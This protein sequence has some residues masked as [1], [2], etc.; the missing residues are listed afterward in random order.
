MLLFLGGRRE[1]GRR[2]RERGGRGEARYVIYSFGLM[3]DE[4]GRH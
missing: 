2:G 3:R 4:M 1:V